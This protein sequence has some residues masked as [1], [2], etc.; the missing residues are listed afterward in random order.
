MRGHN[1]HNHST[2]IAPITGR[3]WVH[4]KTVV[5]YSN[6]RTLNTELVAR[7]YQHGGSYA[8]L[9]LPS[10][11]FLEELAGFWA[12]SACAFAHRIVASISIHSP[13][14]TRHC[15][16]SPGVYS[17]QTVS[18]TCKQFAYGTRT[19]VLLSVGA[20]SWRLSARRY[21]HGRASEQT[22]R[23]NM[24]QHSTSYLSSS[25]RNAR[26]ESGRTRRR[27][28][29]TGVSGCMRRVY[30]NRSLGRKWSTPI[31]TPR[32]STFRKRTHFF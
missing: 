20:T 27:Q 6:Y 15:A 2:N 7:L 22:N 26:N 14:Q 18:D 13:L 21:V 11:S 5:K 24:K 32:G 28:R 12:S 10:F 29:D 3:P 4:Y 17:G 8:S 25:Q 16:Y 30:R 31:H 19:T 1:N 9:R 23:R